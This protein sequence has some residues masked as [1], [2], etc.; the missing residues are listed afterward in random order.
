VRWDETGQK[1]GWR[2]GRRCVLLPFPTRALPAGVGGDGLENLW[3]EPMT[4]GV[5]GTKQAMGWGGSCL[6][7]S[8]TCLG[9]SMPRSIIQ[10]SIIA[11]CPGLVRPFGIA[12]LTPTTMIFSSGIPG[13]LSSWFNQQPDMAGTPL[14]SSG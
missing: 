14:L 9:T 10:M 13:S 6:L 5:E 11:C 12:P 7:P 2:L 8:S 4:P 1:V 3:D